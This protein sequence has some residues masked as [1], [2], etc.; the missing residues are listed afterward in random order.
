VTNFA[1]LN[2]LASQLRNRVAPHVQPQQRDARGRSWYRIDARNASAPAEVYVYDII[3]EWGVSA[4]EFVN[5]LRGLRS[6]ALEV[7]INCEGG[8]IFDGL[9]IYEAL[10]R[11]P[12][13]VTAHVD[14]VAAS[15]ASFI[16]QAADERVMARRARLMIHDGHGLV[17][18]NAGEMRAMADILDDLSDNIAEIYA[19]RSGRGTAKTWR[20]AMLGANAADDGTW[21]DA[22]AAVSA[23]LADRVADAGPGAARAGDGESEDSMSVRWNQANPTTGNSGD[24]RVQPAPAPGRPS[25]GAPAAWDPGAFLSVVTEAATEPPAPLDLSELAKLGSLIPDNGKAG[26]A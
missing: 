7:H 19:D 15:A 3:G 8:E 20:A 22:Q 18:G 11:H 10:C 5:E 25:A 17:I 1:E 6:Q 21:Y 9:A 13:R 12:A 2:R 23:G 4:G 16:L 26:A 14:G 24:V